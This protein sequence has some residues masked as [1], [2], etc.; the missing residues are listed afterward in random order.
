[1]QT[2]SLY[3]NSHSTFGLNS[4]VA[5]QDVPLDL[6]TKTTL[7]VVKD[8]NHGDM[9][10]TTCSAT[11]EACSVVGAIPKEVNT[12]AM[13]LPKAIISDD[14]MQNVKLV[15]GGL[16]KKHMVLNG[17][18]LPKNLQDEMKEKLDALIAKYQQD[19]QKLCDYKM[20]LNQKA[21]SIYI[22]FHKMHRCSNARVTKLRKCLSS[23]Y[24]RMEFNVILN[25]CKLSRR[26][27][28]ELVKCCA[29]E[30]ELFELSE[31]LK[32]MDNFYEKMIS[33]IEDI[34]SRHDKII[35][36]SQR[37]GN[38]KISDEISSDLALFLFNDLVRLYPEYSLQ[39]KNI[40]SSNLHRLDQ[41]STACQGLHG[42][43]TNSQLAI[44]YNIVK[45]YNLYEKK[46]RNSEDRMECPL[47]SNICLV[48]S[49]L[50]KHIN[51]ILQ[52]NNY[53]QLK[54]IRRNC[55]AALYRNDCVRDM[56]KD[57]LHVQLRWCYSLL[58]EFSD[59]FLCHFKDL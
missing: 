41:L 30:S 2:C 1:M 7:P 12:T 29:I 23:D 10:T 24:Y 34:R 40:F 32:I 11:D 13:Q 15:R 38:E 39:I 43:S 33:N 21:R 56:Q 4:D 6:T 3:K 50:G 54:I 28:Q 48:Y 18:A 59:G 45:T 52:C 47:S 51:E 49:T 35:K 31:S 14:N 19:T 58:I 8:G 44:L 42:I 36:A 22:S 17:I 16:Y 46:S 20:Q 27:I 55:Y 53:E 5:Q 57:L 26:R 37:T 25:N 9:Q